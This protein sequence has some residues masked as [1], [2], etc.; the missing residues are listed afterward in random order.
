[1]HVLEIHMSSRVHLI[2]WR[3]AQILGGLLV[4]LLSYMALAN[5]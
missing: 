1:M 4:A 2:K 3:M 5:T